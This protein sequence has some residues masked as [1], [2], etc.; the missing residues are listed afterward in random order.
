MDKYEIAALST[1]LSFVARRVDDLR[2]E[3]AGLR[4]AVDAFQPSLDR[5]ESLLRARVDSPRRLR[6]SNAKLRARLSLVEAENRKLHK[7]LEKEL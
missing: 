3:V 1:T 7:L 6:D 5:I 4:K 2:T